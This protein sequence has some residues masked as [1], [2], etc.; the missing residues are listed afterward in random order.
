MLLLTNHG[1][2]R[3]SVTWINHQN[4]QNILVSGA[5]I[6]EKTRNLHEDLKQDAKEQADSGAR[7]ES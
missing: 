5:D 1:L 2:E 3:M 6:P 4:Q 7:R